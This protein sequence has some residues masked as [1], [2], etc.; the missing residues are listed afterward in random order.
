MNLF[1]K[2]FLFY[3]ALDDSEKKAFKGFIGANN[4]DKI[5]AQVDLSSIKDLVSETKGYT[6]QPK[7]SME[8]D[9]DIAIMQ[10]VKHMVNTSESNIELANSIEDI[11]SKHI[12]R[13]P[14]RSKYELQGMLLEA[15]INAPK[16]KLTRIRDKLTN[17]LSKN[18]HLD[19]QTSLDRW[20]SI[21][22]GK[23]NE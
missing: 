4:F 16:E 20:F 11:M 15:L 3:I 23:R 1:T 19:T 6:N 2:I 10:V 7:T 22:L 8:E 12:T 18:K 17:K 5:W 9:Y 14:K 13:K 21:I